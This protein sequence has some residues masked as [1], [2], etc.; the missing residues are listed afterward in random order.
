MSGKREQSVRPTATP[1]VVAKNAPATRGSVS[2]GRRNDNENV[3]PVPETPG[4]SSSRRPGTAKPGEKRKHDPSAT[5]LSPQKRKNAKLCEKQ[6]EERAAEVA[7]LRFERIERK[8]AERGFI[9]YENFVNEKLEEADQQGKL[10]FTTRPEA[11]TQLRQRHYEEFRKRFEGECRVEFGDKGIEVPAN[12][13]FGLIES[14]ESGL[15]VSSDAAQESEYEDV[16]EPEPGLEETGT[17][18][19]DDDEDDENVDD[20]LQQEQLEADAAMSEVEKEYIDPLSD[21]EDAYQPSPQ[22]TPKSNAK[23]K[24]KGKPAAKPAGRKASPAKKGAGVSKA[25]AKGKGKSKTTAS[26]A[27][28]APVVDEAARQAAE[29]AR[30]RAE[31]LEVSRVATVARNLRSGPEEFVEVQY[32]AEERIPPHDVA[33]KFCFALWYGGGNEDLNVEICARCA[34]NLST[35]A[36]KDRLICTYTGKHGTR[37]TGCA[38]AKKLC[39]HPLDPSLN[40]LIN[41]MKRR[42]DLYYGELARYQESKL[43]RTLAREIRWGRRMLMDKVAKSEP[44]HV[45]G[46]DH[47]RSD[48]TNNRTAQ[49]IEELLGLARDTHARMLIEGGFYPAARRVLMTPAEYESVCPAR[50]RFTFQQLID[51]MEEPDLLETDD[52]PS[53]EEEA[54]IIEAA[55]EVD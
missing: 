25:K 49:A 43:G 24:G 5:P 19:G 13:H 22:P 16:A 36:R 28:A 7:A 26:A 17:A 6:L 34:R 14:K 27:K 18:L 37:C 38:K 9:E 54:A 41:Q 29:E 4:P 52:E 20:Q 45:P 2:R 11:Y 46:D 15:S 47:W 53:D 32:R 48:H 8:W 42:Q 50:R 21:D 30:E 1:A 51:M 23:G 31:A 12:W 44:I 39:V 40:G 10:E 55:H 3:P 33:Q 35:F